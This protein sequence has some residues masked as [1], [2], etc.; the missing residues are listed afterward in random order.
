ME[1]QVISLFDEPLRISIS[2]S[3]IEGRNGLLIGLSVDATRL[4]N[5]LLGVAILEDGSLT[6][7]G[8]GDF[9][10]DV[11][12]DVEGDRW[13]GPFTPIPDQIEDTLPHD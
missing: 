1:A 8:A 6:L 4:P 2:A 10:V 12:Y 7:L 3:H 13:T 9:V 11:T 5:T